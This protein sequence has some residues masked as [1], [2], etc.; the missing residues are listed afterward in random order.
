MLITNWLGVAF[1]ILVLATVVST[2]LLEGT[3][4]R[5]VAK[6]LVRL[7]VKQEQRRRSL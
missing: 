3:R 2:M 1:I 4:E 7:H 6:R 5:R